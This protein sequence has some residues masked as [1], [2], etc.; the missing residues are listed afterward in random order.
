MASSL[1]TTVCTEPTTKVFSA[2]Y[3][4]VTSSSGTDGLC[5]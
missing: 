5:L 3:S 4:G 2:R 1:S